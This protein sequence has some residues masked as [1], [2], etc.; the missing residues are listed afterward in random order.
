MAD[1]AVAKPAS[2]FSSAMLI[3]NNIHILIT[4]GF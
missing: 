3:Y 4:V 1:L 2:L